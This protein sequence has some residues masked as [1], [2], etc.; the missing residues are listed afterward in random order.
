MLHK[1]KKSEPYIPNSKTWV[2]FAAVKVLRK[3]ELRYLHQHFLLFYKKGRS[4]IVKDSFYNNPSRNDAKEHD[5]LPNPSRKPLLKV[6]SESHFWK[7]LLNIPSDSPFWKSSLN[8]PFWKSLRLPTAP[9][10]TSLSTSRKRHPSPRR[11]LLLPTRI[12]SRNLF[13]LATWCE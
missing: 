9:P 13:G 11:Q 6:T 5:S 8:V 3:Q 12:Y 7:A 2:T 1:N 4:I 10:N